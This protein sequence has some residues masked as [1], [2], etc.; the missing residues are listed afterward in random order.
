M[1]V[2]IMQ[3]L[4]E[5]NK[6]LAENLRI[7]GL[8]Q[9]STCDWPGQIV[10]TVFLQGCP[11]RCNY[12]HNT[13][14]LQEK[15]SENLSWNDVYDFIKKRRHLL[16]GV[17]FSGGE[18]TLQ[19]ALHDAIRKIHDL[20]LLVGL[21]SAGPYPERL[22]QILPS[23]D[24]IGFDVKT[25]FM[26]YEHITHVPGSGQKALQS[27]EYVLAS[28]IPYE[29]RTTFDYSCMPPAAIEQL[30]TELHRMGVDNYCIQ[31]ARPVRSGKRVLSGD[32][33]AYNFSTLLAKQF[34]HSTVRNH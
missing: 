16:D 10:T 18:P 7:G 34:V 28:R 24:W 1:N 30:A 11:W 3:N 5:R 8:S 20:G 13:H 29:I 22:K 26:H 15:G 23:V 9:F 2:N 25:L 33:P 6:H 21:H 19:L 12:C 17:V 32:H 14:L 27:L 31:M 4:Q